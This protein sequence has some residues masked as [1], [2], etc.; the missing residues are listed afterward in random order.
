M[1]GNAGRHRS[2][3]ITSDAGRRPRG[4]PARANRAA[5]SSLAAGAV[6]RAIASRRP[7]PPR[8]APIAPAQTERCHKRAP[9]AST[10]RD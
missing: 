5:H 2:V 6:P 8:C 1:I 9:Y 10:A 7:N 4:V 3:S